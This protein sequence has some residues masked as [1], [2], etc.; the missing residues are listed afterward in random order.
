MKVQQTH[1]ETVFRHGLHRSH[2]V[3]N[4]TSVNE[5]AQQFRTFRCVCESTFSLVY[6]IR[7]YQLLVPNL[8][9]SLLGNSLLQYN[10]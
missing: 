2:L 8:H 1:V 6:F 10:L 7:R 9:I 5:S 4:G 3:L